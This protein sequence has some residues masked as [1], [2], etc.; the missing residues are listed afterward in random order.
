MKLITSTLLVLSLSADAFVIPGSQPS[1]LSTTTTSTSLKD[2]GL[3]WGFDETGCRNEYFL[4]HWSDRNTNY[5]PQSNWAYDPWSGISQTI[6]VP[7]HKEVIGAFQHEFASKDILGTTASPKSTPAPPAQQQQNAPT[8]PPSEP[9]QPM[10]DA[11]V[12]APHYEAQKM[13]N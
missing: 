11:Q 9:A 3:Q 6:F 7:R 4:E 13:M 10:P 2:V 5:T 12:A 1:S 8:L